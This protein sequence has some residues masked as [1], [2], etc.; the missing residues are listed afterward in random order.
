MKLLNAIKEAD[1]LRPNDI[2]DEHKAGWIFALEGD[3]AEMY[4]VD[5][6][7]NTFPQD[8]ELLVE[9]PYDDLYVPYLCARIDHANEETNLYQ[10]D[11][12]QANMLIARAKAHYRRHHRYIPERNW[13]TL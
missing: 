6:P 11:M 10:A 5:P 4:G 13:R 8:C 12:A 9:Y 7:A 2:P 1:A 3:F